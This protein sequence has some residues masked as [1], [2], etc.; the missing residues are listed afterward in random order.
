MFD[1]QNILSKSNKSTKYNT[2]LRVLGEKLE[3]LVSNNLED[4][5]PTNDDIVYY[6]TISGIF[7][8]QLKQTSLNATVEHRFLHFF[9]FP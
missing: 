8:V 2:M 3:Q 1:T 5:E 9:L 4:H 7:G 6:N